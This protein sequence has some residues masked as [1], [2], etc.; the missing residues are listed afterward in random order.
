MDRTRRAGSAAVFA[1][2]VLLVRPVGAVAIHVAL[3]RIEEDN[4]TGPL[5]RSS[6]NAS[7]TTAFNI[8][9]SPGDS[10]DIDS[11][12][13]D[14][15]HYD[16]GANW[17]NDDYGEGDAWPCE[18]P[19]MNCSSSTNLTRARNSRSARGSALAVPALLLAAAA[20]AECSWA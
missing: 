11:L 4:S 14:A 5:W 6:P 15:T 16:N 13:Y 12:P 20:G 1:A 19:G 9:S 8:T 2:L 18:Y 7:T 3:P 17:P 10:M